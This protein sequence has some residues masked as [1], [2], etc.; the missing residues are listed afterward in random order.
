MYNV[1]SVLI[2]ESVTSK[3]VMVICAIKYNIIFI[4]YNNIRIN[5]IH[6]FGKYSK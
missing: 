5:I 4:C 3:I 2:I 6:R 1:H